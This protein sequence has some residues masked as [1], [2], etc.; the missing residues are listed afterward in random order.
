[1]FYPKNQ[2][3]FKM[4]S[5]GHFTKVTNI[6]LSHFYNQNSDFYYI[7]TDYEAKVLKNVP[8]LIDKW[9][10]PNEAMS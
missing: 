3:F 2:F 7:Y 9:Q 8:A 6:F 4:P 1:M 5:S 10:S